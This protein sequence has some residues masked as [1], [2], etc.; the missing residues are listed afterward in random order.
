MWE[1]VLMQKKMD[2]MN[3]Q[4]ASFCM[5]GK[6]GAF[7]IALRRRNRIVILQPS[8]FMNHGKVTFILTQSL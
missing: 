4:C 3:K 5:K 2:R 1:E 8:L 7:N 6:Q